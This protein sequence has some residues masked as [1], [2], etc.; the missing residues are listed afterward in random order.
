[1]RLLQ[2]A[3]LGQPV[4]RAGITEVTDFTDPSLIPLIQDMM[5]TVAYLNGVGIAAPQVFVSKAILIIA[6]KPSKRYPQAPALAPF[7]V[8]NPRIIDQEEATETMYEGCLSVPSLRCEVPRLRSVTVA[9]QDRYGQACQATWQGF[10]A[11]IF[12]HEYDHL[13]GDLIVDRMTTS[14]TLLAESEYYR[15][16]A[17]AP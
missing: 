15:R 2:V 1:M 4:L 17:T 12:Q 10:I 6:S 16:L 9:Y 5:A 7:E 14:R 11:R 3:Q 13:Q 8:I